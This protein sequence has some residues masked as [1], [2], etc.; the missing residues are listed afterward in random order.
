MEEEIEAERQQ[1]REFLRQKFMDENNE[2]LDEEELEEKVR[3]L[4]KEEKANENVKHVSLCF[5]EYIPPD[6][7]KKYAEQVLSEYN[8]FLFFSLGF[9]SFLWFSSH[10]TASSLAK[11]TNFI[12][13]VYILKFAWEFDFLNCFGILLRLLNQKNYSDEDLLDSF[14][15]KLWIGSFR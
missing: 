8:V 11:Y 15:Y 12:Y 14:A 1:K 10:F 9:Y 7:A 13:F 4:E 5:D 3:E 2:E 6:Q